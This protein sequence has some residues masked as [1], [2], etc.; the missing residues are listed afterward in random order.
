MPVKK[1]VKFKLEEN[2]EENLEESEDAV[3]SATD[4]AADEMAS[5]QPL[6]V[7]NTDAAPSKT[8]LYKPPTFEEL[9]NLKEAEMLF[10]SNLLKLQVHRIL[11]MITNIHSFSDHRTIS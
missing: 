1:K 9:Q 4:E 7:K 11:Y 3:A 5:A 2:L 10:Q 8:S 6:I